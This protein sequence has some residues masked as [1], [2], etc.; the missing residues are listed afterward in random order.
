[1]CDSSSMTSNFL[2]R[3]TAQLMSALDDVVQ[4]R[5]LTSLNATI[6]LGRSRKYG[7]SGMTYEKTLESRVVA[8]VVA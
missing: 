6:S 3:N 8:K 1:M 2:L 7:R 4:N 5:T